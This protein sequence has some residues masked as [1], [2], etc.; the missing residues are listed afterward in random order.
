MSRITPFAN[1]REFISWKDNN[2]D[3]CCRY[4]NKS[5]KANNAR[6]R[7]AFYLDLA[8]VDDG[9][10]SLRTANKIGYDGTY[11]NT[12]CNDFDKPIIRKKYPKK[13]KGQTKLFSHE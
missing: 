11:L 9:T 12:K 2:C 7:L 3:Q 8:C 5:T 13:I 4:E 10:I 1:L 6:C